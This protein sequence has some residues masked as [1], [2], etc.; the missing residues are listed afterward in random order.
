MVVLKENIKTLIEYRSGVT[1]EEIIP[2]YV[3]SAISG[4][5]D[6]MLDNAVIY[7]NS[8]SIAAQVMRA[9]QTAVMAIVALAKVGN[10]VHAVILLRS[11]TS[12][13]VAEATAVVEWLKFNG[14]IE[15]EQLER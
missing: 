4:I 5:V 8:T 15:P 9:A 7:P 1:R 11:Y 6:Y 10:R 3:T 13:S 14:A 2:G 12:V